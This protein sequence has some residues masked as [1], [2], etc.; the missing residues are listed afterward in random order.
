[1]NTGTNTVNQYLSKKLKQND[2]ESVPLVYFMLHLDNFY[3]ILQ[4]KYSSLLF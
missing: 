4:I 3:L 2:G 1:M